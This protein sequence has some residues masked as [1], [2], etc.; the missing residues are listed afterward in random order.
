MK[1]S[2]VTL[3]L[4]A[5]AMASKAQTPSTDTPER[6]S[7]EV[8]TDGVS[9]SK[10]DHDYVGKRKKNKKNKAGKTDGTLGLDIGLVNFQAPQKAGFAGVQSMGS[11]NVDGGAGN[12]NSLRLNTAKSI[13]LSLTP[14]LYSL[15]LDKKASVN[16][17]TGLGC[18]WYNLRYDND[19][20]MSNG[21]SPLT[22]SLFPGSNFELQYYPNGTTVDKSKMAAAYVTAPLMLQ[23]KPKVGSSR[24][25]FGAGISAG[26]LLKGWYKVKNNG[27][28]ERFT[29]TLAFNPWQLNAIGEFGIDDKIRFYGSYALNNLYKAPLDQRTF[30]VGIRFFGL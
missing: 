28:S 29:Q 26:Y 10:G 8:R 12:P 15:H 24:L 18:N 19:I 3:C 16:I 13:H 22:D 5:A 27:N 9:V 4:L 6:V 7:I 17:I 1:Q 21:T 23:L 2:F 25:V 11:P 14:I 30:T 20:R